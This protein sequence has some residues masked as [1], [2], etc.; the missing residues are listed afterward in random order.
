LIAAGP[1]EIDVPGDEFIPRVQGTQRAPATARVVTASDE[2]VPR[3][4]PRIPESLPWEIAS[5]D[6][7]SN[8]FDRYVQ[9]ACGVLQRHQLAC[10]GNNLLDFSKRFNQLRGRTE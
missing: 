3:Y 2:C 7:L 4:R 9:D 1:A 6:E 5:D 10:H 8:A